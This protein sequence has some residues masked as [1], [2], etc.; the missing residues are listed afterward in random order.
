MK[1]RQGDVGT[2]VG[3][4]DREQL[5]V[6]DQRFAGVE[7]PAKE[8]V[9]KPADRDRLLPGVGAEEVVVDRVASVHRLVGVEV[10]DHRLGADRQRPSEHVKTRNRLLQVHEPLP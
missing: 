7:L 6:F 1:A 4:V 5:V 9:D 8:G 10:H 2:G 3:V